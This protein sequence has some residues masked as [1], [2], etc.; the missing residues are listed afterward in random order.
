MR[1]RCRYLHREEAEQSLEM[2]PAEALQFRNPTP[3]DA[4]ELLPETRARPAQIANWN[5][6]REGVD[7]INPRCVS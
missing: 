1:R 4:I 2:Q 7:G 6:G 3:D 5:C